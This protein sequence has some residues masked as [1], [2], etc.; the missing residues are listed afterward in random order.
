[1]LC[2]RRPVPWQELGESALRQAGDA[3][4]DVGEPG[5]RIDSVHLRGDDQRV[6]DGGSTTAAIG[7][8]EQPRFPSQRN[9]GVI[10][11]MSGALSLSTTL[12][13]R[14][15]DVKCASTTENGEPAGRYHS[16]RMRLAS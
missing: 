11:P 3:G 10:L 15:S 9:L 14:C 8:G 2:G 16:L 1:M 4:E 13:I 5:L 7:A 12:G 6:D